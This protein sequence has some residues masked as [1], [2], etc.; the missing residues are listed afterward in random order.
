[1]D[2]TSDGDNMSTDHEASQVGSGRIKWASRN[3]ASHKNMN[4]GQLPCTKRSHFSR[5]GTLNISL[6]SINHT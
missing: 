2:M 3:E 1:M 5:N 4:V 6:I